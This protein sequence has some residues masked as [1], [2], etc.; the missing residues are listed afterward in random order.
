MTAAKDPEDERVGATVKA[1]RNAHGLKLGEMA[2][3]LGISH[4]YLSNI[5]AG[6]KTA[7]L[8]L[9]RQIATLLRIPLAAITVA[10]YAA[11]RDSAAAEK[12]EKA[13]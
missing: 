7:P 4:S 8:P 1:L 10:D 2:I 12:A 3:A 9:C 13:A 6:R 5:E 11:I